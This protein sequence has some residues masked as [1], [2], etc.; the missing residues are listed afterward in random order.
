MLY[1]PAVVAC[2]RYPNR[3]QGLNSASLV[4]AQQCCT[5]ILSAS[6]TSAAA[7]PGDAAKSDVWIRGQIVDRM[8]GKVRGGEKR[9]FNTC[10]RACSIRWRR[11][12]A[13]RSATSTPSL[14]RSTIRSSSESVSC[15][16]VCICWSASRCGSKSCPS[17]LGNWEMNL[18]LPLWFDRVQSLF[19]F[20]HRVR[21]QGHIPS[22]P[23]SVL[24]SRHHPG[25]AMQQNRL[26][27][28]QGRRPAG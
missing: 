2:L 13:G 1:G 21:Q 23:F 24:Q 14:T 20:P 17:P 12:T 22:V 15:N 3:P 10:Q 11:F 26:T 19:S 16:P 4:L 18:A 7:I 5:S 27:R 25:R 28:P 6:E 8:D 9:R